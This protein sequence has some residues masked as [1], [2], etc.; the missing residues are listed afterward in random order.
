LI[1]FRGEAETGRAVFDDDE[2][3]KAK[4]ASTAFAHRVRNDAWF[5]ST[6]PV[7]ECQ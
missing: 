6:P 3:A 1:I 5:D 4:A 7:F 2:A